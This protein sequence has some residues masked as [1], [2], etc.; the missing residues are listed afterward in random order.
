M[1][2][3]QYLKIGD[4]FMRLFSKYKNDQ[5]FIGQCNPMKEVLENVDKKDYYMNISNIRFESLRSGHNL[6]KLTCDE[7]REFENIL[8]I[9]MLDLRSWTRERIG[10]RACHF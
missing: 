1:F 4:Y 9:N 8:T 3:K 6:G 7:E 10:M 2:K 5:E